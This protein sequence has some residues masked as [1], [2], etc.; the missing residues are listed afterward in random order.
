[1]D[2][3]RNVFPSQDEWLLILLDLAIARALV[4]NACPPR[5]R[6]EKP[7]VWVVRK[8][9]RPSQGQLLLCHRRCGFVDFT[10]FE[11]VTT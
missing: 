4:A 5:H 1:M 6:L 2:V 8:Q 10:G 11:K 9:L 3:A 7:H